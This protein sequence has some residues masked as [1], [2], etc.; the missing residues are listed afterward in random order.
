MTSKEKKLKAAIELALVGARIDELKRS[1]SYYINSS[2]YRS[3]L[4]QL[5]EKAEKLRDIL[6]GV[7]DTKTEVFKLSFEL[8]EELFSGK[9]VRETEPEEILQYL[10]REFLVRG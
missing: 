4:T 6:E 5:E 10:K 9:S 7:E 1:R 2:A 3:R 8:P